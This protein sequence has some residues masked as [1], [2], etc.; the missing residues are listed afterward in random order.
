[1]DLSMDFVFGLPRTQRGV[2]FVFVVVDKFSKMTYFI[3][4]KKAVDASNI[5]KL[6]FREAMRLHGVPKSVTS[7]HDIKFLSHFWITLW[8]MFETILNRNFLSH[9]QTDGKIEHCG[10][11]CGSR[12]HLCEKSTNAR[13]EGMGKKSK[14]TAN[15]KKGQSFQ[16]GRWVIVF[17]H[18]ER[19][20]V[21]TYIK[22][23]P[24]K[25]GPFKVT[26]MIN[27]NAYLVVLPYFMNI[28]NTF[29][30]VDMYDFHGDSVLYPDENTG[31]SS[32]K[33]EETDA[34]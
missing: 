5:S 26:R 17:L 9:P 25:Y 19:F 1:M 32:S 23:H 10:G 29:N 28:S 21:G 3:A 31:S 27:V 4:C 20:R 15:M 7:D 11:E 16:R 22:L 33:V 34:C 13:L 2:D 18:K 30:M 24:R 8:R 6:F 14:I 12:N